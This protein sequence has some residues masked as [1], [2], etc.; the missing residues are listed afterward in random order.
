[1]EK[2]SKVIGHRGA[3]GHAPENTLASIARAAEMGCGWVEFDVMLAACGVPVVIHDQ[4]LDRT[5][6]GHG[7]VAAKTLA[8][9]KKLDAGSWFSAD[10]VGATIP[11]LSEAL[12]LLA[13]L[14]LGAVVEIKPPAAT[15]AKTGRLAAGVM[16][17]FSGPKSPGLMVASFS[18][19]A[20]IGAGDAAPEIPRALNTDTVPARWREILDGLGCRA[21]HC[22]ASKLKEKEARDIIDAGFDL[23]CYTVNE[24]AEAEKLFAWG[25][26]GVFSDF[27]DRIIG[28]R[29]NRRRR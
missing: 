15:E 28:D 26:A 16:A 14:G 24:A 25:V 6:D 7:R 5:T 12:T 19:K 13:R 18:T 17:G 23:R 4:T 20:L 2:P 10:F 9:L 27:P 11:A 21:L 22:R 1:M 3:A 29:N 8:E